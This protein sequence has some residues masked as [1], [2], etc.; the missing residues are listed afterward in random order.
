MDYR[1]TDEDR[2]PLAL[3]N[4]SFSFTS[5]HNARDDLELVLESEAYGTWISA[6]VLLHAYL[7][8]QPAAV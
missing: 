8:D 3:D 4:F 6:D 5:N 2:V 1:I 7:V